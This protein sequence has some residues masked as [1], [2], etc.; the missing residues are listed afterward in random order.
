MLALFFDGVALHIYKV[1]TKCKIAYIL[2]SVTFVYEFGSKRN[3]SGI[4]PLYVI[5]RR[6]VLGQKTNE[7]PKQ[8][9]SPLTIRQGDYFGGRFLSHSALDVSQ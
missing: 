9:H 2:K 8:S 1:Y 7:G 5:A 6:G 3:N 4:T